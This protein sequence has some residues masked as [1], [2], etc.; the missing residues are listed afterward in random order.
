[1]RL[2]QLLA[3]VLVLAR[4]LWLWLSLPLSRSA[5]SASPS[6][7]HYVCMRAECASVCC[8]CACSV[9]AFSHVCIGVCVRAVFG[10][11]SLG[12]FFFFCSVSSASPRCQT[13]KDAEER[14]RKQFRR[15]S[16][17]LFIFLFNLNVARIALRTAEVIKF[18]ACY[19]MEKSPEDEK[20]KR[21]D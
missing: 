1:M 2:P 3:L 20:V 14:S 11:C 13:K 5:L 9:S 8:A 18:V 12:S 17:L 19:G 21:T 10:G 6:A 7:T 4:S 15:F 16:L